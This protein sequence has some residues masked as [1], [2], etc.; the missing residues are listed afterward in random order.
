MDNDVLAIIIPSFVTIVG[1]FINYK[2]LTKEK[3]LDVYMHKN[4][5][6]IQKLID[7]P[8]DIL[9]YASCLEK[10]VAGG[11]IDEKKFE[12]VKISVFDRVLCYGS[13]DAV[14][15]LSY[16]KYRLNL[17]ID[18]GVNLEVSQLIVPLI[19]LLMQIKYDITNIKTSPKAWYI[20]Y[21]SNKLLETNFYEDSIKEINKI[22]D[23]LQLKD[24]LRVSKKEIY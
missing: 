15:I 5:E 22:V 4:K 17:G 3:N 6:Q 8:M 1:F 19:L 9:F 13:E 7:V 23:S 12:E 24:F 20:E 10:K 11:D 21:T 18:D 16:F 2:L 14:K